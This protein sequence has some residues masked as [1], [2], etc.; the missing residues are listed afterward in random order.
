MSNN[1]VTNGKILVHIEI[2]K[3]NMHG[4]LAK[5]QFLLSPN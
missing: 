5:E 4:Y 2:N 1:H 3:Q